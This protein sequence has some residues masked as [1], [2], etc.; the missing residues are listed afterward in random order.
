MS[1]LIYARDYAKI[2]EVYSDHDIPADLGVVIGAITESQKLINHALELEQ[3]G[4]QINMCNALEEL[5]QEGVEEGRQEGRW[6]GILEG[7]RATV[8][9]CRNFNISE[10]DTVRNIMNEFSLSQEE[11]VNYVKKYW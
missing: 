4:G 9:T 1:R 3:R 7:I 8:R 11:A 10:A 2:K 6:E 5:R